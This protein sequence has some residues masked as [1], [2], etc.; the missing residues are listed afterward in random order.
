VNPSTSNP[1]MDMGR[2][3]VI[4]IVRDILNYSP[5]RLSYCAR[6]DEHGE[7]DDEGQ[8]DHTVCRWV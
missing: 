5:I 1:T 3:L 2:L 6:A 7:H 8:A 4:V